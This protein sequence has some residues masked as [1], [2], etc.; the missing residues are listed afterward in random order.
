[1][2]RS[3]YWDEF[4]DEDDHLEHHGI[5]GMKWGHRKLQELKKHITNAYNK[6]VD[7]YA[8][9][10]QNRYSNISRAEAEKKAKAKI[11]RHIIIGSTILAGLGLLIGAQ[12]VRSHKADKDEVIKSGTMMNRI[13]FS[14]NDIDYGKRF[15]AS[16]GDKDSKLYKRLYAQTVLNNKNPN[17][18]SA[19][20]AFEIRMKTNKDLKI[21]GRRAMK[22]AMEA[23]GYNSDQDAGYRFM[24]F[25]GG[26]N[27]L[28]SKSRVNIMNYGFANKDTDQGRKKVVE[29]LKKQG[30]VG[31]KD[32]NDRL[33]SGYKSKTA[34]I[35][36]DNNKN[37]FGSAVKSAIK[38]DT[39]DDFYRK[40]WAPIRGFEQ[41][42]SNVATVVGL[43]GIGMGHQYRS[44]KRRNEFYSDYPKYSAN[45]NA[46][47]A[48]K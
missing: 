17:Y 4:H 22:K 5:L 34:T 2:T 9:D 44:A 21:A 48:K 30:Y 45:Q 3:S 16:F 6:H 29:Y 36:F 35:M 37:N 43:T 25:A 8:T 1:M 18:T 28:G 32:A 41:N 23:T 11:T 20:S 14:D 38:R 13:Q 10:Y 42:G 46:R 19:T 26:H 7:T 15:Y 33:L 12:A 27:V 40:V 39:T 24:L 47:K 31:M